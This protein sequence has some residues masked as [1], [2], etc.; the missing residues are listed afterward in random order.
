MTRLVCIALLLAACGGSS[1]KGINA[2]IHISSPQAGASVAL[3]TDVDKSVIVAY[4]LTGFTVMALGSCGSTAACG[5]VHIFIDGTACGAP[6]NNTSY[7]QTSGTAKFA[8]CASGNQ[9]GSHLLSVELHDDQ[10]NPVNDL[11]GNQIKD[12]VSITTH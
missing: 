8:L 7:S 1:A 12:S 11:S 2:S 6:Y 5:H 9:T 3:G 4:T 10:H